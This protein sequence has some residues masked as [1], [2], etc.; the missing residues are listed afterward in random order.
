MRILDLPACHF[1][2]ISKHAA[3][4]GDVT[5]VTWPGAAPGA[6]RASGVQPHV[7]SSSMKRVLMENFSRYALWYVCWFLKFRRVSLLRQVI[8]NKKN[9]TRWS[10]VYFPP[11]SFF[12]ENLLRFLKN[13]FQDK[14][15]DE[16][17]KMKKKKHWF[18]VIFLLQIFDERNDNKIRYNELKLTKTMN[19]HLQIQLK[20]TCCNVK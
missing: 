4:V 16:L 9:G 7:V 10:W 8:L 1:G 17:F 19:L 18:I 5:H 13:N 14:F 3:C 15:G 11:P 20:T 2:R 12:S 6:A